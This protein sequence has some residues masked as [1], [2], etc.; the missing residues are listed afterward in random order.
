MTPSEA[1]ADQKAMVR[2]EAE[3]E[4]IP[5]TSCGYSGKNCCRLCE[6]PRRET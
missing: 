5:C 2:Q 6:E 4:D 1:Y 3:I